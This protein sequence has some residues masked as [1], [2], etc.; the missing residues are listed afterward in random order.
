MHKVHSKG[1]ALFDDFMRWITLFIT[2]IRDGLSPTPLSLEFILPHTG[3]ERQ[4]ILKEVDGIA[5]HHYKLKLAYETKVRKRFARDAVNK[6][7][8]DAA[9]QALMDGIVAEMSLGDVVADA[10]TDGLEEEDADGTDSSEYD[11]DE[12]TTATSDDE[13]EDQAPRQVKAPPP[14]PPK[15][16]MRPATTPPVLDGLVRSQ[17]RGTVAPHRTRASVDISSPTSKVI[18]PS[19]SMTLP[20][21]R[22]TS[23]SQKAPPLPPLGAGAAGSRPSLSRLDTVTP[24]SPGAVRVAPKSAAPLSRSSTLLASQNPSNGSSSHTSR[25][26]P[27]AVPSAVAESTHGQLEAIPSLL[28]LFVEIMRPQLRVQRPT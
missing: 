8:D 15:S 2:L 25:V 22:G 3:P 11:S 7:E 28:P 4:A 6:Q 20:S 1:E 23:Q 16:P 12:Y 17:S 26:R 19:R 9:T 14:V 13:S 5:L 21:R 27:A 10:E 18:R 24:P